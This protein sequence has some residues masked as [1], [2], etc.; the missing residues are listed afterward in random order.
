MEE[1]VVDALKEQYPTVFT[2]WGLVYPAFVGMLILLVILITHFQIKKWDASWRASWERK[3]G[4][5]LEDFKANHIRMLRLTRV[6][7]W[8]ML[9]P[10]GWFLVWD[11]DYV[12]TL[13]RE[14][15]AYERWGSDLLF[16][17]LV[18]I[19][20]LVLLIYILLVIGGRLT[21][22]KIKKIDKL[23]HPEP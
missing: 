14:G 10:L 22:R 7:K 19:T 18:I 12:R 16:Y 2:A 6:F 4:R 11:I 15:V 5:P 3:H 8:L 9:L 23:L 13:L 20:L 17:P 1:A 21:Q